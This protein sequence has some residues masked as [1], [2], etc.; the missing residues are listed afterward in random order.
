MLNSNTNRYVLFLSVV[1]IKVTFLQYRVQEEEE[2]EVSDGRKAGSDEGR[3]EQ[4]SRPLRGCLSQQ[5][6][7]NLLNNKTFYNQVCVAK[8]GILSQNTIF[9]QP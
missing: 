2:E 5:N 4:C 7:V 8:P 9:C 1:I 6:P 3:A